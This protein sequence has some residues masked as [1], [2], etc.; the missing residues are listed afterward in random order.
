[1]SKLDVTDVNNES[2]ILDTKLTK[3]TGHVVAAAIAGALLGAGLVDWS[4]LD[5]LN[6]KNSQGCDKQPELDVIKDLEE[7]VRVLKEREANLTTLIESFEREDGVHQSDVDKVKEQLS[8]VQQERNEML[9]QLN[10]LRANVVSTTNLR[11]LLFSSTIPSSFKEELKDYY[12]SEGLPQPTI[13]A[14]L[15]IIEKFSRAFNLAEAMRDS[16]NALYEKANANPGDYE[17]GV[18]SDLATLSDYIESQVKAINQEPTLSFLGAGHVKPNLDAVMRAVYFDAAHLVRGQV[19]MVTDTPNTDYEY[20]IFNQSDLTPLQPLDKVAFRVNKSVPLENG[21]FSVS[22]SKA[23]LTAYT[24]MLEKL[25]GNPAELEMWGLPYGNQASFALFNSYFHELQ[26]LAF[27]ISDYPFRHGDIPIFSVGVSSSTGASSLRSDLAYANGWQKESLGRITDLKVL[28]ERGQT[29]GWVSTYAN[30]DITLFTSVNQIQVW[31]QRLSTEDVALLSRWY[32][33][34][35]TE[36][37]GTAIY[38]MVR[39]LLNFVSFALQHY[40]VRVKLAD[41][42]FDR[43]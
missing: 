36:Y 5:V 3:T 35:S 42:V 7:Q 15:E 43:E 32:R 40:H 26:N 38:Y 29:D 10:K 25:S 16:L 27:D 34:H 41:K 14:S 13:D 9:A 21:A 22:S 19:Y 33:H 11:D 20:G 6:K 8:L 37:A 24:K 23:A 31:V 18:V 12:A 17:G 2:W 28:I 1:M 30:H 39:S 4:N